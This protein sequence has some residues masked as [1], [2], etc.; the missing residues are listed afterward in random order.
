M[1]RAVKLGKAAQ[2]SLLLQF[3]C[4]QISDKR[5]SAFRH[6]VSNGVNPFTDQPSRTDPVGRPVDL[7]FMTRNIF[8]FKYS[9]RSRIRR[10]QLGADYHRNRGRR[11]SG[12]RIPPSFFLTSLPFS[13]DY[14]NWQLCPYFSL[15]L[16][17]PGCHM[18]T[19]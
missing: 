15:S 17:V 6:R 19:K 13:F 9:S 5:K 18:L 16:R 3:F 12:L 14:L 7:D 2:L 11:P 4:V 1:C 8:V 10:P